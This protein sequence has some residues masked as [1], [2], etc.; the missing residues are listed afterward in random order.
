MLHLHVCAVYVVQYLFQRKGF[1][2]AEGMLLTD[3]LHSVSRSV[4]RTTEAAAEASKREGALEVKITGTGDSSSLNNEE[5]NKFKGSVLC[6]DRYNM[7]Q[8]RH[9][10]FYECNSKVLS[11]CHLIVVVVAAAVA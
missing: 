5:E 9:F 10:D 6:V 8:K 7:I 4:D 3:V 11:I 1:I 2:G